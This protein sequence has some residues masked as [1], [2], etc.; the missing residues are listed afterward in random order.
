MAS[1][2]RRPFLGGVC[3]EASGDTYIVTNWNY[4]LIDT[5]R[6]RNRTEQPGLL[7]NP[8]VTSIIHV[9]YINWAN[10]NTICV[11]DDNSSPFDKRDSNISEERSYEYCLDWDG[12]GD[13][14]ADPDGGP[15]LD[16]GYYP[17]YCG[18]I[19]QYQKNEG[20]SAA[21][22]SSGTSD[23]RFDITLKDD[24]GQNVG[25]LAYADGPT[26]QAINVDSKL[27]YVFEVTAGSV[28]DDAVSF[29]YAGQ[30][31]TSK[32]DQCKFGKYDN[33]NREEDCGFSC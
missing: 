3:G 23:Y 29:A 28:D 12:Y 4:Q 5:C 10:Q 21:A 2:F 13:D 27:P 16:I 11:R 32:D 33:G 9:D 1:G 22:P 7:A 26:G 30:T 18:V 20:P 15:T 24:Q 8:D 19:T 6:V 25:G 31:W 17:D 14:P